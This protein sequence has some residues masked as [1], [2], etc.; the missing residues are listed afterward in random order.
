LIEDLV[1]VALGPDV[2]GGQ[3]LSLL[4]SVQHGHTV[5]QQRVILILSF[6]LIGLHLLSRQLLI[7]VIQSL[8]RITLPNDVSVGVL[9]PRVPG[10]LA[11]TAFACLC[12]HPI[13]I[14]LN[15]PCSHA[16]ADLWVDCWQAEVVL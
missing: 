15:A 3:R 6:L 9:L 7:C 2:I 12:L 5:C 16:H 4:L 13:G 14:V 10:L 11:A 8:V 1:I